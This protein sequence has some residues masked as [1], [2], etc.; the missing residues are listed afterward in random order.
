MYWWVFATPL[1]MDASFSVSYGICKDK[2]K[3]VL[4]KRLYS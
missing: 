3:Q 1:D 2:K 4:T